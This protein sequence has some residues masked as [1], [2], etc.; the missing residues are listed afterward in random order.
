LARE[1]ERRYGDAEWVHETGRR[2]AEHV[3]AFH[4]PDRL[5][6]E[7]GDLLGRLLA[8]LKKPPERV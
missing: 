6:N 4:D 7:W 2:A 1:L 5:A 3:R 8:P